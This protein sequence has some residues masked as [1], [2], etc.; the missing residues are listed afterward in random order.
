MNEIVQL[1]SR[2]PQHL[3]LGMVILGCLIATV[4]TMA[5]LAPVPMC[6]EVLMRRFRRLHTYAQLGGVIGMIIIAIATAAL[7]IIVLTGGPTQMVRR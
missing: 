4:P 6:A 1:L 3:Y 5:L 2:V 7:T